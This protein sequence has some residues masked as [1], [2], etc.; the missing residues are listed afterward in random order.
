[1]RAPLRNRDYR[2]LL[3]AGFVSFTGDWILNAGLAYQVYALTGSTLAS[4]ATVLAVLMPKVVL[5]SFAGVLADRWDRRRTM[6]ACNLLLAGTLLP[7]LLIDRPGEVPIVYP[8]IAVHSALASLFV[9]AEAALVPSLVDGPALVAANALNGQARDVARLVGAAAGGL[10]AAAG[11]IPLIAVADTVTFVA[12]AGLLALIRHRAA[13][14]G[15]PAPAR[16]LVR[17][18]RE[19]TRIAVS[20]RTLRTLLAFVLI[21]GVGEAVLTTLMAPFVRGVLH[22]GPGAYGTVLAAQAIG[23]LAGGTVATLAGHR[24]PARLLLGVGALTFGVLD[25]A[26]FLYPSVAPTVWPAVLI[27]VLVGV[28]GALTMAGLVTIFQSATDDRH[29]GR[30]FGAV[31]AL[32]AA[33]MLVGVAVAGLLADRLGIVPV[34]AVQAVGYCAAGLLVLIVL[35]RAVPARPAP[36]LSGIRR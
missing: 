30:V 25:L 1:M 21:T 19:G 18:W 27:M 24:F 6:I 13:R 5:G 34:I 7:L 20:T 14:S 16:H 36:R 35:P 11:G 4:A 3:A 26:L 32:E 2:L 28:P 22:G 9:S 33:A 17:E 8:V 12:A 29:R 31:T 23:G 15:G 10:L